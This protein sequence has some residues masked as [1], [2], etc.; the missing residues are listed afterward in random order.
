MWNNYI[1]VL[2]LYWSYDVLSLIICS[3]IIYDLNYQIEVWEITKF[4]NTKY[5]NLLYS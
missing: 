3:N 2:L 4:V 1:P 5:F